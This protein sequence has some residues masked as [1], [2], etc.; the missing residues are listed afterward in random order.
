LD[1]VAAL[2]RTNPEEA[3][4][5]LSEDKKASFEAYCESIR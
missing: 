4:L 1:R 5:I 2:A 3:A